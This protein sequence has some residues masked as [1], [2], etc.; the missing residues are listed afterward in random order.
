MVSSTTIYSGQKWMLNK[1]SRTRRN[2]PDVSLRYNRLEKD[3]QKV[4]NAFN[5][6]LNLFLTSKYEVKNNRIY[7]TGTTYRVFA[8]CVML[9]ANALCFF[10]IF[11]P[12][13]TNVTNTQF[14]SF[15]TII[16]FATYLLMFM[17]LF[18]LDYMHK[19]NNVLLILMIQDIYKSID[20]VKSIRS[21]II[22]SWISN[23]TII[24][25]HIFLNVTY[26]V[27]V[28]S[29]NIGLVL[30]HICDL[31]CFPFDLNFVL[32]IRIIILLKKYLDKWIEHLMTISNEYDHND[33]Y[34]KMSGIYGN[35]LKA[36][37]LY[38]RI[39]KVLVS[40]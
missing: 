9:S 29:Y 8:F 27:T 26:C 2:I 37:S 12:E 6:P 20:F 17:M 38:N 4:A 22:W 25:I 31:L 23:F 1:M 32:A 16:N 7:A 39:F 15:S 13:E 35:I 30:D 36:Y 24:F 3:I 34:L 14:F 40:S 11:V 10:R 21:F 19:N 18:L 5:Y 33:E 28:T